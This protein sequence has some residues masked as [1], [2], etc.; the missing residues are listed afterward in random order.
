MDWIY[1][2]FCFALITIWTIIIPIF[3]IVIIY[4]SKSSTTYA[5]TNKRVIRRKGII[6]ETFKSSID[7]INIKVNQ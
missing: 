2:G 5:I 7:K 3:I 6:S 4:L 1:L